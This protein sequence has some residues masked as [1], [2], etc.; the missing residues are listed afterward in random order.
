M[1]CQKDTPAEAGS[2]A[3]RYA[4][5]TV[6]ELA[7]LLDGADDRTLADA[8]TD[9]LRSERR[10]SIDRFTSDAHQCTEGE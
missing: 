6:M 3:P 9:T 1:V 10:C 4:A 5:D 7:Q 8:V 2:L